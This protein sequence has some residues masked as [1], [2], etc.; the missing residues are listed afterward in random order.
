MAL[1]EIFLDESIL[2]LDAWLP[3]KAVDEIVQSILYQDRLELIVAEVE[4]QQYVTENSVRN[5]EVK[6][7]CNY[8]YTSSVQNYSYNVEMKDIA[9]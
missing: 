5:I 1:K 4:N 3:E 9:A 8:G 2:D 6:N 7:L